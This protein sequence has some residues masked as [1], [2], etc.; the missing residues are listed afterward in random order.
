[1]PAY[2]RTALVLAA[3]TSSVFIVKRNLLTPLTIGLEKELQDYEET[4]KWINDFEVSALDGVTR[5]DSQIDDLI[6]LRARTGKKEILWM[7]LTY[8]DYRR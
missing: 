7:I 6:K 1:M 2:I 3:F 5:I 4:N 8:Y